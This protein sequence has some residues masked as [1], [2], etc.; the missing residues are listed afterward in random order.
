M[1]LP[2]TLEQLR[3]DEKV[4]G[5]L[6]LRQQMEIILM[7]SVHRRKSCIIFDITSRTIPRITLH[8]CTL[9]NTALSRQF[10]LCHTY[11]PTA[12]ALNDLIEYK[13]LVPFI[14]PLIDLYKEADKIDGNVE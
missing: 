11:L 3:A 2:E 14:H 1:E 13:S 12:A 9:H 4:L 10:S 7:T 8:S 5:F 6:P